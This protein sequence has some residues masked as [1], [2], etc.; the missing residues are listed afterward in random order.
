[1]ITGNKPSGYFITQDQNGNKVEGETRMCGHCQSK[2]Q[3]KFGQQK[4]RRGWCKVCNALLCGQDLC[5]KY[6]IPYMDKIEGYE[7]RLNL[8]ELIKTSEKKYGSDM[9]GMTKNI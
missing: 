5:M 9:I 1:M 8:I 7:K 4:I 3:Y 6:H 2:W